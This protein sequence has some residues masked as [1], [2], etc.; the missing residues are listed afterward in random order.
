MN[1][2]IGPIFRGRHWSLREVTPRVTQRTR[3]VIQTCMTLKA[4][5]RVWGCPG[6]FAPVV[7]RESFQIIMSSDLTKLSG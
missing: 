3:V 2:K 4:M 1:W 7:G 6:S 5:S